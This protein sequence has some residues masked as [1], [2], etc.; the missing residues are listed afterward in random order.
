MTRMPL[1]LQPD[2]EA[3]IKETPYINSLMTL[4]KLEIVRGSQDKLEL[5]S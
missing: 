1:S 5:F 2:T 4:I 3:P